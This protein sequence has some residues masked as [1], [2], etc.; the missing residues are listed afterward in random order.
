M[1]R[2][3]L[4]VT[5][6]IALTVA[7]IWSVWPLN[8]TLRLGKDLRGGVSL[9]YAVKMPPSARP[10][11]V[12]KQVIDVL[13]QRV[14][15]TGVLDISFVPQGRDRIEVVMPLPGDEVRQK[16]SVFREALT[17]LVRRSGI[18]A[19]ELNDSLNA[20]TAAERFG[21]SDPLFKERITK[22]QSA[23]NQMKSAQSALA[24]ATKSGADVASA[25]TALAKAELDL[26]SQMTGVAGKGLSESRFVRVLSLE[27]AP[28]PIR[29]AAGVVVLDENGA[30]KMG[31]SDRERGLAVIRSEFPGSS[32][33]LDA[34]LAAFAQYEAV[35]TSLDDPEDLKR[36]FRGAGVLDFRI[37]MSNRMPEGVNPEQM[38]KELTERGPTGAQSAV[39]AWFPINDPKQWG[40]TPAQ[41]D[42]LLR[43]PAGYFAN[44]DLIGASYDGKPYL[45]LATSPDKI[46]THSGDGHSWSM[47]R[48]SRGVDELGRTSVSFKLDT[49]GGQEMGRLTGPHV[50]RA[51]AIVLDGQVY[52]APN[53]QSRIAGSGQITGSFD[54]EE[55]KYLIRVLSAG[56]LEGQLSPEPVSVNV[57]GP[58]LGSDNLQRGL[59]AVAL[60]TL[61][62]AIVK[63]L[64]YL[65][66]G[67][68]ADLSLIVNAFLIFGVMSF[69]DATF[70]LPG[71][72]GV[73]LS[74]AIAVDAN[75][76]IYERIRE[77]LVINK[78]PLRNA[79]RLGFQRAF[80][81]IFDGNIANLIICSILILFAG[82]EVKGFGIT[83]AIGVFAT[84]ITGLWVTRVFLSVWTDWLG[85][86]KLPM[87]AIVFPGV[88][89]VLLPA[90]DWIRIRSVL[91]G[92]AFILA[93]VCLFGI[94]H[95]G[96]D[97]FETEF[98]GGVS[99]TMTTRMAKPGEAA[100][101]AGHLLLSRSEV[102]ERVQGIG[103]KNPDDVILRE[104]GASTALTVGE[105]T[106]DF[107]AATFQIKIPNPSAQ[108]DESKITSTV[109]NAVVKAFASEMDA[110]LPSKFNGSTDSAHAQHTFP[111]ERDTIGASIGRAGMDRPVG[112]YRGGVALVIDGI[113]PPVTTVDL[114]QRM[115][116]LRNQPDFS[117][118]AGR[119]CD[120][121]GFDPVKLASG[122]NGF[123]TVVVLVS[124]STINSLKSPFE[125]WDSA[126]AASEWKL[127][128]TALGQ[129]TTLD[130]VSSFSPSVA[131]SLVANATVAV[132]ISL[133][134]ML[135]YIWVRFGSFR[136]SFSTILA[137][138]FNMIV[139]L[140][141]L[142]FS[143][144]ISRT[145][146]GAYLSIS[147]FRIDL[148]VVAGL[149]T[150]L[151]Y[152]LN[153]TVV[154]LD[155]VRENRGKAHYATRKVVNSSINQSFG[156]TVLTGGNSVVTALILFELGGAG[157]RPFGYVY[158]VGVLVSTF[159]SVAIAATLVYRK[160]EDPTAQEMS[161]SDSRA[162]A[163]A[164][165]A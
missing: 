48:A 57:L 66:A 120:V 97:I 37:A 149:L 101:A 82:T 139:C 14:N 114:K 129:G 106:A 118:Q 19:T 87:L 16:Q 45:L 44:R 40:E 59:Y 121:I 115:T 103:A 123:S 61:V 136:F 124:D 27:R 135:G 5:F 80:A 71:L 38:R 68:I 159:S 142:A 42:A 148:N 98:R 72:A 133:L 67:G 134:L 86:K 51:M 8:K 150:V 25:E 164:L 43:D 84:F 110:Q 54:E 93:V 130:Q 77:E 143:G 10:E 117:A 62:L 64:Y 104:L 154:I 156:R 151:G 108:A 63:I 158:F 125:I 65:V 111:L 46:L 122:E 26:E 107:K 32:K 76:L 153:D 95:R 85:Q 131:Q 60:S 13:K 165:P 94:I 33:D 4:Q 92:G 47:E 140:G 73:A 34:A 30:P 53:L 126:L 70:T 157:L 58:S 52:T 24:E 69:M 137:L 132:A 128:S 17:E 20:G 23:F 28:R 11:Q 35:R 49:A 88:A 31:L 12:L 21:G 105:Q 7:L 81:A 113:D 100:N 109:T 79:I 6:I 112:N 141:A 90:I 83:M 96:S 29:D 3:A 50:G 116:R 91:V 163:K 2:L 138:V 36:L 9:V 155:R 144:M 160:D 161:A 18:D 145:S 74:M 162:N 39:A 22:L 102:E 15:P 127:L 99:I 55:I 78:E 119:E 75:V 147:D 56:A 146:L 1:N 152:G 41:I 89:R